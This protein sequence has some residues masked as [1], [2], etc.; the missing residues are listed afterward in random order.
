M[1]HDDDG[2]AIYRRLR[3]GKRKGQF[4]NPPSEKTNSLNLT[5]LIDDFLSATTVVTVNGEK[6]RM[7]HLEAI[8]HQL[9]VKM[10]SQKNL[11]ASRV[12]LKYAKHSASR[13]GRKYEIQFAPKPTGT[14]NEEI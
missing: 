5:K 3:S 13:G 7:T 8:M 12:L 11:R 4:E 2:K 6:R 10:A 14:R 9:W 1:T